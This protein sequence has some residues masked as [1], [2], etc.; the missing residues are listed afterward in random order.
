MSNRIKDWPEDERPRER[1]LKCGAESLSIA[2]LLAIFLRTGYKGNSA[3]DLGRTLLARFDGLRGLYCTPDREI[4]KINGIG[5]AKLAQLRAVLELAHRH[6]LEE[7]KQTVCLDN[8]ETV[9]RL[10][11]YPLRDMDR[12]EFWLI[13]LDGRNY[14]LDKVVLGSGTYNEIA[15]YPREI[16]RKALAENAASIIIAHNHPSGEAAPSEEDK[17]FTQQLLSA[18]QV[19]Q[20]SLHDH[21]VVGTNDY[22][23]FQQNDLLPIPC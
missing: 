6:G 15:A 19:V 23:S 7:I 21:I 11:L 3:V 22:F 18:C 5:P 4:L 14:L 10:L 17:V 1:M 13:L 8:S 16:I 20:L 12:E 2:E 9:Y